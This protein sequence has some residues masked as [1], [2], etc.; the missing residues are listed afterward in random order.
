M[1]VAGGLILKPHYSFEIWAT[2]FLLPRFFVPS[3]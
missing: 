1:H 2:D 3:S